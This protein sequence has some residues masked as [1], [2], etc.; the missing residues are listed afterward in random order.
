MKAKRLAVLLTALLASATML[1]S[2]NGG[3]T[4]SSEPYEGTDPATILD[5]YYKELTSWNN[6]LDLKKKLYTIIRKNYTPISY[7]KDPQ[8][9]SRANWSTNRNADQSLTNHDKVH[10][11]YIDDEEF[12]QTGNTSNWQ[13]EHCFPASLMTGL[14]TGDA[15]K[16]LGTATDFHNLYAS[17]SSGNSAHSNMSFGYV[18]PT[19]GEVKTTGNSKYQEDDSSTTQVNEGVF[20]PADIDKGRVSRAVFYMAVMYGDDAWVENNDG[21]GHELSVGLKI[22]K[23]GAGECT[24]HQAASGN[25]CHSNLDDIVE[26]NNK[27]WPD[28]LE[29]QHT[30]YVQSLQ[31]NRNPFVDFP[32]LVDY[33]FGEKRLESG[34]LKHLHNIYDIL[35]MGK[36]EIA[37]VAVKNVKYSYDGGDTFNSRS[38]IEVYTTTNNFTRTKCENYTVSGVTDGSVLSQNQNGQEITISVND[39]QAKYK[40]SVANDNWRNLNYKVMP[41]SSILKGWKAGN[42][43]K[44]TLSGIDWNFSATTLKGVETLDEN[45]KEIGVSVGSNSSP[46]GDVTIETLNTVSIDGNYIIKKIYVEANM[47]S[48]YMSDFNIKY[49][50]GS[51]EVHSTKGT[52]HSES[53][54]YTYAADLSSLKQGAGKV[55]IVIS[56]LQRRLN[57]GRIGLL[58]EKTS[59]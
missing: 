55:K 44:T 14:G 47:T 7:T 16:V 8:D 26:W 39:R 20:E 19:K 3:N 48:K 24:L 36:E 30:T 33:V 38:D 21:N 57:L 40:I 49:Y 27:F 35:S 1:G 58:V 32:E 5:G 50:I 4:T 37:D 12:K 54:L 23:K 22:I 10:L 53:T 6:Y 2:C 11:L 18:D 43:I 28:R 15:V 31:H 9:T 17:Y 34:E 51:D 59:D 46:A 45:L 29:Y 25:K 42:D 41:T 56:G 13:R 52:Y